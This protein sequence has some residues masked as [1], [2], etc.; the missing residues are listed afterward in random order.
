MTGQPET[1]S[2][3]LPLYTITHSPSDYPGMY[4]TRR[5]VVGP[6]GEVVFDAD[7]LAVTETLNAARRAVPAGLYNLGREPHDD[8]VIVETW[9]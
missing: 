4:V 7:P 8:S 9:V 5:H 6:T 3:D 1:P 2:S